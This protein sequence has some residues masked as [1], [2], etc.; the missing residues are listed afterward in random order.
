MPLCEK[1]KKELGGTNFFPFRWLHCHH[2][3]EKKGCPI[4]RWNM[5]NMVMRIDSN[6]N[7]PDCER[8]L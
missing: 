2:E 8:K 6:E 7:L 3:E 1:C 5:D 4:L